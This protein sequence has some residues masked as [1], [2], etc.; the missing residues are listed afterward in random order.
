MTKVEQPCLP[1]APT[2]FVDPPTLNLNKRSPP[3]N[4]RH[5]VNDNSEPIDKRRRVSRMETVMYDDIALEKHAEQD[6][7]VK[8]KFPA[9]IREGSVLDHEILLSQ[10]VG[11][12]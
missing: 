6:E 9:N 11:N 4:N 8:E 5:N 3:S 1:V 2:M 10:I 12:C 7:R